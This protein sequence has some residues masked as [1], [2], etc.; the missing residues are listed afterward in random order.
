MKMIILPRQARDKHRRTH[1]KDDR[2]L[3]E[4]CANYSYCSAG[5]NETRAPLY[6]S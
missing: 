5:E 1:S 4:T 6:S 2:F 3:A